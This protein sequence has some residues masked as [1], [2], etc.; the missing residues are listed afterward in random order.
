MYEHETVRNLAVLSADVPVVS[1]R[2]L[3]GEIEVE[4]P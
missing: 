3:L 2:L 1:D 4:A